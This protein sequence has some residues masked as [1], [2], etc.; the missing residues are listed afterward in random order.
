MTD[1][2]V[3]ITIFRWAGRWGPFRVKI[4]CG[5]CALSDAVVRDTL[6]E[7]LAG[8]PVELTIHDWLTE[9]WRPLLRGG[10]HA[11]IIMVENKVVS[12]GKALNRGVLTQE[13][14]SVYASHNPVQGT[15][16]FGKA[17]CPHCTQ[18]RKTLE[19]A[20]THFTYHDVV[21]SP[22]ALYEMLARVKPLIGAKTPVTLPQI[23]LDG[24]FLGGAD[25]LDQHLK[26]T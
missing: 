19:N 25:A 20:K 14:M 5:E 24:Q 26:A 12:Q 6:T 9:W 16:I 7:E 3:S 11:P 8:I 10:W 2:P 18:A 22:R 4:P 13:V 21:R 1:R 15:H 17:G 23:W